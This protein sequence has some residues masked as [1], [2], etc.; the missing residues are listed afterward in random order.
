L[1]GGHAKPQSKMAATLFS[2]DFLKFENVL[3]RNSLCSELHK[4]I[5]K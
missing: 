2:Y 5:T 3:A 1:R 4:I